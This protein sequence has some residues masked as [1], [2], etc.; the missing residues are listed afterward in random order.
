MIVKDRSHPSDNMPSCTKSRAKFQG[1]AT[2]IS[3]F[4]TFHFYM[5]SDT[6]IPKFKSNGYS[7]L[8]RRKRGVMRH[9][10]IDREQAVSTSK[11]MEHAVM[12]LFELVKT[13][14][15]ES[16][17]STYHREISSKRLSTLGRLRANSKE[18]ESYHHDKTIA[19]DTKARR[20]NTKSEKERGRDECLFSWMQVGKIQN[21][22]QP[23]IFL[24]V[25]S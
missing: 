3:L 16:N 12:Q 25:L 5:K 22:V 10:F 19:S 4:S 24:G 7:S 17:N 11:K 6:S 14:I 21:E 1:K 23:L 9:K 20:F 15:I 13:D 8:D 18:T 2:C